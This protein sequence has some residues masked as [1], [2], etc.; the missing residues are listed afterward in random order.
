MD[1]FSKIS[2]NMF[3]LQQACIEK[4][5]FCSD[6][7]SSCKKIQICYDQPIKPPKK[8]NLFRLTSKSDV[9]HP[10]VY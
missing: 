4:V 5:K 2:P 8:G 9:L 7:P 1:E 6:G 3:R 10:T